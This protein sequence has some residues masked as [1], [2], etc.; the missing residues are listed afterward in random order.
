MVCD[1]PPTHKEIRS[2]FWLLVVESQ[3]ANLTTDL[4][5]GYNLCFRYPNGWCEPILDIYISIT[6]QWYKEV[7]KPMG[8]GPYNGSLK[9]WKSFGTP[10]PQVGVALGVWGFILSHSLALSGI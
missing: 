10:T 3:S 7:F 1:T 2:I 6:F 5:F 9:I 4:S 8:L